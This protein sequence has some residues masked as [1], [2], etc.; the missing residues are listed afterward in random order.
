MSV[1][2][3]W[4]TTA[5]CSRSIRDSRKRSTPSTKL[6]QWNCVWKPRMLLP[7]SPARISSRQGQIPNR[8][9]FGQGMC[10]NVITVARGSFSRIIRGSRAKW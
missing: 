10:Q 6:L 1:R 2:C 7:R 4:W 9:E 3:P 5:F 8:S